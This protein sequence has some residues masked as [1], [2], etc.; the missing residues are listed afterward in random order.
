MEEINTTTSQIPELADQMTN[1]S[2]NNYTGIGLNNISLGES[3]LNSLYTGVGMR[4]ISNS[5]L[6]E[7]RG[8]DTLDFLN[9]ISTNA[10][11]NIVKEEIVKT[12]FTTE[13]GRLIDTALV[14]NLDEYKLLVSSQEHQEK[15]FIWLQKYV[16]SDDVKLSN[17]NGKYT[18][19]EVLGPQADSFM[20]LIN[21]NIVNNIQPNTIKIINT[22]GII[23]F[24]MKHFDQNGQLIYWVLADPI[25]AQKL[26]R[27]MVE[28]KGPFNFNLIGEET[29]NHY[30]VENGFPI[31]PNEINDLH[32]PNEV[33]LMQFIS[34]TKGCFIGQEVI[35]RLDT[36][37]KVQNNLCG[38]IFSE[39]IDEGG[40]FNLFDE[41]NVEVGYTTSI[42][43]SYRFK[44]CIGLGFVKS[45][46]SAE[47][48]VLTAKN[49]GKQPIKVIVKKL[50]FKK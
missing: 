29:Y 1:P 15:M 42:I 16:I 50:P 36:Y 41:S 12:I 31:A 23:F 7:L 35:A 39:A 9:R 2:Q 8:N 34:T 27:Y 4:D 33:G 22:E 46:Y 37:D 6:I 28:N 14:I 19:L 17:I 3:E 38:F 32:H 13:K 47:G 49:S 10:V 25:Y 30:R 44:K 20:T 11:K 43:Y 18:L 26:I 21:G 24:L 48:T 40:K 5:G 45:K